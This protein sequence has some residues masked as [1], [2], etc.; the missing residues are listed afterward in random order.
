ME[1]AKVVQAE[2]AT[3]EIKKAYTDLQ[4]KMNQLIEVSKRLKEQVLNYQQE[5]QKQSS[6]DSAEKT[7]LTQLE[8]ENKALTDKVQSLVR[9]CVLLY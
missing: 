1:Q 3:A 4:A 8:A 9:Q 6:A 2:Q 5:A 7:R